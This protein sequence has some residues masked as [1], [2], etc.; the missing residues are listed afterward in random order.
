MIAAVVAC[1]QL[2]SLTKPTVLKSPDGK[3]QLT[4]PA[5]WQERPSLNEIATIKAANVLE[6]TYVMVITENKSDFAD[7]MTLDKF[8]DITRQAMLRKA[9]D[10]NS[11]DPLPVTINGSDGRQYALDGI[12]NGVKVSYQVV[13][14]ETDSNY[15]QIIAWTLQSRKAQN[16]STL[17]SVIMSFRAT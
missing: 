4:V 17:L 11:T 1:K 13:A 16:N 15:H 9:A 2:Q 10:S 14:L 6:E 3:F 8:T 5:G 7:D 12:V